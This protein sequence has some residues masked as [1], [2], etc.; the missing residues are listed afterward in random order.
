MGRL[1]LGAALCGSLVLNGN[2]L[3]ESAQTCGWHVAVHGLVLARL[4]LPPQPPSQA[5]DAQVS[6]VA[7]SKYRSLAR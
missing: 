3:G 6:T 2:K 7:A 1:P 4:Y 5:A